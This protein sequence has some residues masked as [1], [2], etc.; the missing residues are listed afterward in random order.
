[1]AERGAELDRDLVVR[2]NVA[3]PAVG[4]SIAVG[5][6][7]NAG[8]AYGLVTIVP[9]SPEHVTRAIG[10]DLCV[11][12][13]TSGSM[14]GPP[15]AQACR[16]TAALIDSLG[17]EDQL[18]LIEFSDA[19]RRWKSSSIPATQLNRKSAHAWLAARRAGGG[20]DMTQA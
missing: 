4:V 1:M 15:L 18:E 8:N 16:V 10:R 2:W 6:P 20:T 13:D 12:L 19:A 3:T 5:R 17:D 7:S 9:P 11:L 14:G